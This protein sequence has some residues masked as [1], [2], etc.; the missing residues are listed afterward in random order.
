[1]PTARTNDTIIRDTEKLLDAADR[2]PEEVKKAVETERQLLA[3]S[4]GEVK[5]LKSRQ[6]ELTAQRQETT[7]QLNVAMER[8]RDVAMAL[9]ALVKA[10]L[11]VRN[12][13]LVQ[14]NVSPLRKRTRR[15]VEKKKKKLP[16]DG[17]VVGHEPVV[18]AVPSAPS[19]G[20]V[21]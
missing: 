12:E 6:V 10:K 20:P 16:P 7:Q 5:I 3:Q 15:G 18:S 14:Y 4:V 21:A 2:S 13:R 17:G 1:M 19:V 8:L 9:R 11:G